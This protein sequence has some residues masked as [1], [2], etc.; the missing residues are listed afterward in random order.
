ML[1]HCTDLTHIP[2]KFI[3]FIILAELP[4]VAPGIQ[5]NSLKKKFNF[6]EEK[7][8]KFLQKILTN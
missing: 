1:S 6:K 3:F 5:K 2:F 4:G 7:N 8:F